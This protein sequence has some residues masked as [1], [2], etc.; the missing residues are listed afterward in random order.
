MER[1]IDSNSMQNNARVYI[2]G[3]LV[4]WCAENGVEVMEECLPILYTLT[5]LNMFGST[6]KSSATSTSP[7]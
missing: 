7:I 2:A 4:D 3:L 1:R 6:L 5:L